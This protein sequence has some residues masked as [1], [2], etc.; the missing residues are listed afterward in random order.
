MG[1]GDDTMRV[2]LDLLIMGL[3]LLL[4]AT[5]VQAWEV[6]YSPPIIPVEFFYDSHDGPGVRFSGSIVTPLGTLTASSDSLTKRKTSRSSGSQAS[7]EFVSPN[8]PSRMVVHGGTVS[9]SYAL[10][11]G[12]RYSFQSL[13]DGWF[14]LEWTKDT[15]H[16]YLHRNGDEGVQHRG[17]AR[18]N[19]DFEEQQAKLKADFAALRSQFGISDERVREHS[20]NPTLLRP[21]ASY[22]PDAYSEQLY[23][24][25]SPPLNAPPSGPRPAPAWLTVGTSS[26]SAGLTGP[27]LGTT[28]SDRREV[29]SWLTLGT[30]DPGYA[31]DFVVFPCESRANRTGSSVRDTSA[32]NGEGEASPA[33]RHE[34]V[35]VDNQA[36]WPRE[37]GEA[38]GSRTERKR[39]SRA[40]WRR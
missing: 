29:P 39:S 7:Q 14:E 6:S 37:R 34:R 32:R 4:L 25:A 2:R 9:R 12:V 16:V 24:L 35:A 8:R 1:K 31:S 11:P 15:L 19:I 17:T 30:E 20:M 10:D 26:A 40:A 23:R 27:P 33:C 3:A 38:G 18:R 13:A 36:Y 5:P 28:S 21:D 22:R